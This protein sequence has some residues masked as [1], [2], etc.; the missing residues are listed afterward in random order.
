MCAILEFSGG[1]LPPVQLAPR[2][3][4]NLVTSWWDVKLPT[5]IIFV[6]MQTVP[7][8]CKPWI[9]RREGFVSTVGLNQF[10]I[11]C[12]PNQRV[13]ELWEANK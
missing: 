12:N 8:S 1:E 13:I 4:K 2:M 5:T 3:E 9:L 11:I 6:K 7:Q 10:E